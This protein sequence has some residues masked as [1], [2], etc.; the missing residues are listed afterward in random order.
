MYLYYYSRLPFGTAAMYSR[1]RAV[2][3]DFVAL[4]TSNFMHMHA[5]SFINVVLSFVFNSKTIS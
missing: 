3:S 5:S 1:P 2:Q 4:L